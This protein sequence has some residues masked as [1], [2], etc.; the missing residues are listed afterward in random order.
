L[1]HR[2]RA[3]FP[4]TQGNRYYKKGRFISVY[5]DAS[6]ATMKQVQNLITMDDTVLRQTHLKARS[7][8]DYINNPH[9]K[10]NPYIRRVLLEEALKMS[11]GTEQ[12]EASVKLE[13]EFQAF[14]TLNQVQAEAMETIEELEA[15]AQEAEALEAEAQETIEQ[16]EAEAQETIQELEAGAQEI[17]EELEAEAITTVEEETKNDEK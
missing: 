2:F 17:M 16:L 9:E 15:E 13:Q 11:A 6:P 5:Y 14:E 3:K 7:V 4:D 10:K 1:P 8:L 12:D